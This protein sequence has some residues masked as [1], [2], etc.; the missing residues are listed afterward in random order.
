VSYNIIRNGTK[1]GES[2]STS[3]TDVGLAEQTK[4]EYSVSANCLSGLLSDASPVTAA[5]TNNDGRRNATSR[6]RSQPVDWLDR[7]LSCGNRGGA[8]QRSH[9]SS[10]GQHERRST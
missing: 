5:S 3:F 8:V 9:G 10:Y 1:V 7:D 6:Y 4:F 2:P